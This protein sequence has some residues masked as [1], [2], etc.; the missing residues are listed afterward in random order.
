MYKEKLKDYESPT[1]DVLYLKFEGV[2]CGSE[3]GD[4]GAPGGDLGLDDDSFNFGGF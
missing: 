3:F 2:V 1:I 4:P